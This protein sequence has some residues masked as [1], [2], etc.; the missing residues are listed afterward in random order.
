MPI[1]EKIGAVGTTKINVSLAINSMQISAVT[2]CGVRGR[3]ALD[4]RLNT[5]GI[6]ERTLSDCCVSSSVP[7]KQ[8]DSR[9]LSR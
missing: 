9:S 3:D 1:T 7:F 6:S 2:F 8:S 5:L 4:E